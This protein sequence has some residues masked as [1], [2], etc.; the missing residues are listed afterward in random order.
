MVKEMLEQM[1]NNNQKDIEEVLASMTVAVYKDF[2]NEVI[3]DFI[4]II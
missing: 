1:N 2:M 4:H 3:D